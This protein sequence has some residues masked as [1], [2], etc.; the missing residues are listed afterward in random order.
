MSDRKVKERRIAVSV[1]GLGYVGSVTAACLARLGHRVM[2]VDT[3]PTKVELL[4]CG[5]S[6]IVEPGMLELVAEGHRSCRL[7]ATSDPV[8]AIADSELTFIAVGTPGLRNGRL[9]LSAIKRVSQEIGQALRT[10][11]GYH[12]VV[13]RST[14]LPGT[15]DSVVVPGLELASGKRAGAD[16][17]VCS[18][19]EFLREGSAIADFLQPSLT[20]LGGQDPAHLEPL[21]SLYGSLPGRIVETTLGTAEMVKY[22][23]NTWHAVKV[24]FANEMGTICQ[25]LG[26]QAD[27]VMK[28]FLADTK[29]NISSAYLKPGFAFGGSCLPKDVRAFAYRA[30]QMDLHLPLLEAVLSSNQAHIDRATELILLTRKKKIGFLGLSFKSGTDDLRESPLVQVVKRLL[31]EG[32]QILIYDRNVSW[33]CIHGAN[34]QYAESEIPHIAS[35]LRSQMDEVIQHAEVLVIGNRDEEYARLYG[36]RPVDQIIFDFAHLGNLP[37]SARGLCW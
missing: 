7:H 30:K 21:R 34:R 28:V 26:V 10:K 17:A 14:V 9:D 36:P 13:M 12:W 22:V 16:F 1:F 4:D 25:Q 5:R 20:L 35:L 23:C 31:G 32:R 33:S 18:N 15:V 3:N 19:P 27:E 2:G 24:D 6:P 11:S 8:K 37:S 29:L